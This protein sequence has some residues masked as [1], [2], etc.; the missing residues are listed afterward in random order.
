MKKKIFGITLFF[1][2]SIIVVTTIVI[3]LGYN[4]NSDELRTTQLV[5]INEVQ[6]L[7]NSGRLEEASAKLNSIDNYLRGVENS[8]NPTTLIIVSAISI[9]FIILVFAYI[10]FAILRPF[11]KLKSFAYEIASGNFDI[12]LNYERSNYFGKFTWAFDSMRS[13]IIKAR[14]CEAEAIE[15]NK[16]V[17][18]SL[19]HDIKTPIASINAYAE[20]LEA[21]IDSSYDE[22]SKYLNVIMNKALEVK[23]LT[24]DLFLHSVSELDKISFME[25]KINIVDMIKNSINDFKANT[26]IN[27]KSNLNEAYTLAD[28]MRMSQIFENIFNNSIKYAN[29]NIDVELEDSNEYYLVSIRDYGK[30][31]ADE[32]L[33]FIFEK[34]Y[35]GKNATG[36]NGTGL[37]LYIVKYMIEKM[38]GKVDLISNDGLCA[39]LFFKKIVS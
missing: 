7:I 3:V 4:N 18:A 24:D 34:F 32:D 10:Y 39:K 2:L 36:K 30:G 29:T 20:A 37:G 5:N 9:L 33:P 15:N 35:R 23:K 11:D 13:E 28:R 19:S 38:G 25:E 22:R 14:R 27:F 1:I 21:N 6:Q 26:T 16:T 31:I 8:Y 12:P 17:I